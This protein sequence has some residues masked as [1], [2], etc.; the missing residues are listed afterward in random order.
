MR[1]LRTPELVKTV[2]DQD[3][4]ERDCNAQRDADQLYV[5]WPDGA[6]ILS[7]VDS[8]V[9]GIAPP[10]PVCAQVHVCMSEPAHDE[11]GPTK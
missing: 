4:S 6:A 8:V 3:R 9:S 11:H 7:N 1:S 2:A 10:P 5:D